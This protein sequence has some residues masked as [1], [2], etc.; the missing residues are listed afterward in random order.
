MSWFALI[1]QGFW[2]I[3]VR[4]II[5]LIIGFGGRPCWTRW[6]FWD[7]AHLGRCFLWIQHKPA[8]YFGPTI[9]FI[10]I[11]RCKVQPEFC[12]FLTSSP[13][14]F[15]YSS[16]SSALVLSIFGSGLP[17]ISLL[18]QDSLNFYLIYH[19]WFLRSVNALESSAT[20]W[21]RSTIHFGR[22]SSCWLLI[23]AYGFLSSFRFCPWAN[24]ARIEHFSWCHYHPS[25]YFI[26]RLRFVCPCSL[27]VCLA[28][29]PLPYL[30]FCN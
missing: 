21:A 17:I 12:T 9:I 13:C 11:H 28:H 23:L 22:P 15:S 24:R 2:W 6:N 27:L 16:N 14:S 29:P 3:C 8:D 26:S 19:R 20:I 5:G 7:P 4:D 25:F 18:F 10:S 1:I 30:C